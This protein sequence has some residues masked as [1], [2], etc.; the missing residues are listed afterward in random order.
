MMQAVSI[1]PQKFVAQA[2]GTAVSWH[3]DCED[4]QLA[5]DAWQIALAEIERCEQMFSTFRHGSEVSR[6]NRGE[7]HLLDA[8]QEVVEV[9][10]AC[11]WLEHLSGGVFRA[12]R[13]DGSLDP[14]GFVKGWAVERAAQKLR[15]T[16][17][18]NWYLGAGGDIQTCGAQSSGALW[19]VGV[20]DPHDAS[21]IRCTVDIPV[22]FAI[23]TSGTSAR[24]MHIWDGNTNALVS[25]VASFTVIGPQL[26]W[27]DA[28]A[29]TG[30]VMGEPGVK[31]VEEMFPGYV[32]FSLA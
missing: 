32:A 1:S 25:P 11:T 27:A 6:I 14:A 15:E 26:M 23:A 4:V 19:T 17:L 12:R 18:N 13:P 24:G 3:I 28:L 20:V 29:T 16:G 7:L 9:L 8:S 30:F 21:R 5:Q 10:D 31:W 2:M 22:D